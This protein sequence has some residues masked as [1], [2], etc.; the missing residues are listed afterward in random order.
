MN[1]SR[2][3]GCSEG[4]CAITGG[5]D[6]G[7]NRFHRLK[8][9]DT[10]GLIQH[11]HIDSGNQKN[12]IMGVTASVGS[13]INKSVE[14]S[15]PA[16]LFLLSPGGI[17][18]G[19]GAGFFNTP[20][21]T[22]STANQL[23]FAGGVF[24]VNTST[25]EQLA[26]LGGSP[27]PGS[28]GLL[29]SAARHG[30]GELQ[31]AGIHLD[32]IDIQIAEDLLVDS[33]GGLVKVSNSQIY[34]GDDTGIGGRLTLSGEQINVYDRSHLTASGP[35]GGGSIQIGGSW[36]NSNK[37]VRQAIKT[38]LESGSSLDASSDH[39]GNGGEVVV[40]TDIW[41]PGSSTSANGRIRALPGVDGVGGRVETSGYQLNLTDIDV[42]VSSAASSGGDWLIDPYSYLIRATEAAAI[43]S[44]LEQVDGLGAPLNQNLTISVAND[45][46]A[47][48]SGGSDDPSGNIRIQSDITAGGRG[49]L[50]L[51][52]CSMTS[53]TCANS[54]G[55]II[56]ANVTRTSG[57]GLK[58][59]AGSGIT[60]SGNIQLNAV[61]GVDPDLTI[62]QY[63][64]TS[65]SGEISVPGELTKLGSGSLQ[66]TATTQTGIGPGQISVNAGHL[67][68]GYTNASLLQIASGASVEFNNSIKSRPVPVFV[69]PA[70][71]S[72]GTVTLPASTTSYVV[73]STPA[74]NAEF[75]GSIV[76]PSTA[77]IQKNGAFDYL[78][79][80]DNSGFSGTMYVSSGSITAAHSKALGST[81][82]TTLLSSSGKLNLSGGVDIASGVSLS[83][84]KLYSISGDNTISQTISN[85]G[86]SIYVT[87]G[88]LVIQKEAGSAS[89]S[90]SP[91][92][93]SKSLSV[94]ASSGTSLTFSDGLDLGSS[95]SL[96]VFGGGEVIVS[97]ASIMNGADLWGATLTSSAANALGASGELWFRGGTLKLKTSVTDYSSRL[98]SADTSSGYK[99]NAATDLVLSGVLSGT[100][101]PFVKTGLGKVSL[102]AANTFTGDLVVNQGD[103]EILA[104]GSLS[105][106]VDVLINDPGRLLISESKALGSISGSGDIVLS[107]SSSLTLGSNSTNTV[108]SG[109]ISGTGHIIKTGSGTLDLQSSQAWSGSLRSSQ[110]GITLSN[111]ADLPST[112]SLIVDSPGT[113]SLNTGRTLSLGSL[114]GDGSVSL[115]TRMDVLKVGSDNSSTTYAGS[116]TGMGTLEKIGSGTLELLGS[117]TFGMN[118]PV[119]TISGGVLK[120]SADS[121]LGSAQGDQ[122]ILIKN[123]STLMFSAGFTLDGT[124]GIEFGS[125][126]GNLSVVNAGDTLTIPSALTGSGALSKTGPGTISLTNTNTTYSGSITVTA[127]TL[128]GV[129]PSSLSVSCAG[130]S[131]NLCVTTQSAP[132][133]SSSGSSSSSSTPVIESDPVEE[134]TSTT[135]EQVTPI[136]DSSGVDSVTDASTSTESSSTS[137]QDEANQVLSTISSQAPVE[138]VL[139]APTLNETPGFSVTSTAVGLSDSLDTTSVQTSETSSSTAQSSQAAT[140]TV[141]TSEVSTNQVIASGGDATVQGVEVSLGESFALAGEADTPTSEPESGVA[142]E[143]TSSPAS[144]SDG[145]PGESSTDRAE[146]SAASTESDSDAASDASPDD[147]G[148]PDAAGSD[149]TIDQAR[150]TTQTTA[151]VQAQTIPDAEVAPRLADAD[152]AT[153]TQAVTTLNLP[154]LSGR[155]APSVSEMQ[156]SLRSI[157]ASVQARP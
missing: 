101:V 151:R 145:D 73:T 98:K 28:D 99:I 38:M 50:T 35:E 86:G 55:V 42:E 10:R 146:S 103:V 139:A 79:S 90:V 81:S 88:S 83:N 57:G 25:T 133:Q 137:S 147:A 124:R 144:S 85:D 21:L 43:K 52:A 64:N 94:N 40:W 68:L 70:G 116:I 9:L 11:V 126:G 112:I 113:F 31:G 6:S 48:G 61:A 39:R 122:S 89:Y 150:P 148:S 117:N 128:N 34:V 53:G 63:G 78:L 13:F 130:G 156:S 121:S 155:K 41:N 140:S 111:D 82:A 108:Y 47:Y 54:G 131:S 26:P 138:E 36:Q 49:L 30:S 109:E 24:D 16:H 149:T 18:L 14:L 67:E 142:S 2:S 22:L 157:R 23:R 87:A 19:A 72:G 136:D 118:S 44:Y 123:G 135:E 29:N 129:T 20:K 96:S 91:S 4:S 71:Q 1:G 92:S 66:L 58:L 120:V 104:G 141:E 143:R 114:S 115:A 37:S 127:G 110:G 132:S 7:I 62:E 100:D 74:A 95:G 17:H 32:G 60:G 84:G 3:Q 65:Y 8:S 106:S 56:A 93:G 59:M 45:E 69:N 107:N 51:D 77:T 153:T 12:I 97:S 152:A 125:G 76:G 5:T 80:G 102:S 154:D 33:P 119:I 27:L 134:S 46:A 15:S 75:S 105:P